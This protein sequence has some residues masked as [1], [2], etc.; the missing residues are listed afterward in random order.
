MK[1]RRK[2][3]KF[4][5][6][7]LE[8]LRCLGVELKFKTRKIHFSK[9]AFRGAI[10]EGDI[11]HMANLREGQEVEF[12]VNPVSA[13]G[14]PGDYEKGSADWTSSDPSVVVTPN[15]DNELVA[16]AKCVDGSVLKAVS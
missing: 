10:F 16:K 14:G 1:P 5:R 15:V 13:S 8:A 9:V 6:R 3:D 4:A 12:T 2:M 7:V 11:S